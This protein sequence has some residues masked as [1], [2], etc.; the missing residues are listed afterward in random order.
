MQERANGLNERTD[1][2]N[3]LSTHSKHSKHAQK[4]CRRDEGQPHMTANSPLTTIDSW[5]TSKHHYKVVIQHTSISNQLIRSFNKSVSSSSNAT[6]PL[7]IIPYST[8]TRRADNHTFLLQKLPSLN[9]LSCFALLSFGLIVCICIT[10][11]RRRRN[12]P[13]NPRWCSS[14]LYPR[15]CGES[16]SWTIKKGQDE[17]Q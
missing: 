3:H 8:K 2:H 12:K 17:D 1:A 9:P 5:E 11:R 7:S 13:P 15:C 4:I 14:L 6:P 10:R 16:S